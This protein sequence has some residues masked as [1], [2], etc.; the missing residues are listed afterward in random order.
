MRIIIP[1][2]SFTDLIT[3]SSSEI[4]CEIVTISTEQLDAVAAFLSTVLK[5]PITPADYSETRKVIEFWIEWGADESPIQVDFR[6]VIQYILD[7]EFGEGVCIV[8][9]GSC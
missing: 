3:N 2:Q 6:N 4:F 7:K 5:R 9:E 1:I 8:Q